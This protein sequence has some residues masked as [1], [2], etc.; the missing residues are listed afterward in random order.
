MANTITIPTNVFFD[1]N[2]YF[3][4][5][6]KSPMKDIVKT[7][8]LK[9]YSKSGVKTAS[10]EIV[11]C[12]LYDTSHNLIKEWK[13]GNIIDIGDIVLIEDSN[14]EPAVKNVDGSYT[15]FRVVGREIEYEGVPKII[16]KLSEVRLD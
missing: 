16:L 3:A 2:F 15:Y 1:N 13:S 12:D 11:G 4:G 10:I 6:S 9:D 7:N 5:L 14:N 8:V